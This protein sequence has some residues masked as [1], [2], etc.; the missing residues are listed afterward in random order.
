MGAPTRIFIVEDSPRVLEVITSL[1]G[2]IEGASVAGT[3]A[4]ASGAILRIAAMV[5]DV[6][7]LDVRLASGSGLEVLRAIRA[8]SARTPIVIVFSGY[9]P[10]VLRRLCFELGADYAFSKATDFEQLESVLRT[11]ALKSASS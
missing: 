6:V 8:E 9:M 5:P 10:E 3:S 7:I 4:H 11:L 1:I 2:T